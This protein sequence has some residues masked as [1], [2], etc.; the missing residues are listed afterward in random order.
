MRRAHRW[1]SPRCGRHT[2]D[3]KSDSASLC[4]YL[5]ILFNQAAAAEYQLYYII[6]IFV[7]MLLVS[8]EHI[9]IMPIAHAPIEYDNTIH[10]AHL[11]KLKYDHR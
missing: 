2:H 9:I 8:R 6:I 10:L 4:V 3:S 7:L 11:G 5:I 1:F